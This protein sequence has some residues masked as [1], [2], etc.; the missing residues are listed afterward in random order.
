[1]D[2]NDYTFS[3][4]DETARMLGRLARERGRTRSEVLEEIVGSYFAEKDIDAPKK[5]MFTAYEELAPMEGFR[6]VMAPNGSIKVKSPLRNTYRPE[7]SFL[8]DIRDD[9]PERIGRLRVT[10]RDGSIESI[11]AFDTFIRLWAELEKHYAGEEANNYQIENGRYI[12]YFKAPNAEKATEETVGHAIAEYVG[13]LDRAIKQYYSNP[14]KGMSGIEKLYLA[15]M[16]L[17]I[18]L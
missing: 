14:G 10:L 18:V 13:M 15:F 12:R 16:R 11:R 6:V 4:N 17:G 2:R 1:V 8:L 7:L 3:L 5:M 9:V